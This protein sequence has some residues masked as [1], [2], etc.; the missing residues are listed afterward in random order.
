MEKIL[1]SIGQLFVLGFPGEDPPAPFLDFITEEQI[2]GVILFEENCPTH[3]QARENIRRIKSH[4]Q[5][6]P[7]IIAID[8][9]GGSVCRLRGVPAEFKAAAEYAEANDILHFR[10]AYDRAVVLMTSLGINLNLAP[11]A[12]ISLNPDNTCLDGRC[13]G[14]EPDQVAEFVKVSVATAHAQGLLCCLK[15]FPG[16]GAA[17]VDPHDA[18][19]RSD[20]DRLLWEQREKVP[21]A[22]GVEAGADLVMTTHLLAEKLDDKVVTVSEKILSELVRENLNFDG[23]VITDD[24]CMKGADTIGDY[25]QRAV[26]AFQAGHDLLLFCRDYEA[27]IE[28]YEYFAGAVRTGE[29][30]AERVRASL[31]RVAGIKLKLGRP[32]YR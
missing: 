14:S 32:V 30:S 16:L 18:T 29:I 17:N 3:S 7:P 13:Y 25:G 12:D 8:Q 24:L 5:S 23:P 28:A 2:G 10:E 19:A 11:V 4:G 22:A 21:F 20:Y 26:A 9:E 15:H 27:V 31:D 1:R 6:V